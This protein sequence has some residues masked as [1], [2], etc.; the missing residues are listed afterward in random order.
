MRETGSAL[1]NPNP[2]DAGYRPSAHSSNPP[3]IALPAGEVSWKSPSTVWTLGAA[4][5]AACFLLLTPLLG[6][7]SAFGAAILALVSVASALAV[8]RRKSAR[9]MG[10]MS[11]HDNAP[12]KAGKFSRYD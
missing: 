8:P 1:T 7:R 9:A 4:A 12:R 5:L 3:L 2:G 6:L 11:I 10:S